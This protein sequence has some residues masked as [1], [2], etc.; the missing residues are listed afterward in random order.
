[1]S[2]RF[3]IVILALVALGALAVGAGTALSTSLL[4]LS[5]SLPVPA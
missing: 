4:P 3:E 1:M 5:Y 2:R